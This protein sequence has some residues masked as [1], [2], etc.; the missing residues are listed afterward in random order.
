MGIV[1]HSDFRNGVVEVRR[2]NSRLMLV[3][4]SLEGPDFQPC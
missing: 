2:V 4:G 1:L 3:K